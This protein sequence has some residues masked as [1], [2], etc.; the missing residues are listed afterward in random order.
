MPEKICLFAGT[1]EGHRLAEILSA[2]AEVTACVATEY[3]E[4]LLDG[5]S[6]IRVH[7]G[8]MDAGEMTRFFS[9]NGFSRIIDATHPYADIVT[10]NI[11]AAAQEAGIPVLRIL[12]ESEQI[13]QSAVFVP[14]AASA[15]EWLSGR[16]G[17]ILLTTGSKDLP[18]YQ[19]L[20][21]ERVWARVLPTAAS[22]EACQAAGIP[23]SHIIAAQG[24]FP[25]EIN[26]A[27][28][29]MIGARYLVTK[30]S[31]RA[32]GFEEKL[33]AAEE[34]GAV[35]VI[36]G[37]PAQAQ[38]LSL[39]KAL[40]ELGKTLPI[41]KPRVTVAGI[42][43]G[44]GDLLTARVRKVLED[45]DALIGARSV[46]EACPVRKPSYDAFQPQEIRGILDAHPS[47]RRAAVVMRGDVGFCSGAKKLLG[48]LDGYEVSLEP[49]ISSLAAFAAALGTSWDDAA[50]ISLHG[51]SA[52]LIQ[53]V[54]TNRKTFI[55]TGGEHTPG[56]ICRTLCEFGLGSLPASV[57]ERISYPDGKITRG[58]AAELQDQEFDS[59]SIL[60][61]SNE[62]ASRPYRSGI[63]DEEFIRGDA[64]MTK[65]EVRA[66]S[67]ARLAP[68][69]DAL[70]YD[71]GAGTGSVSVE[72]ALAARDGSVY[73]VEKDADAVGLLRQNRLRF[74]ADNL[75]IVHG[76]APEALES[77]PAPTH[78]F[79]GGSSGNLR[80]IVAALLSKNPDVRIVINAVTLETQAEAA[81][82][83]R[84]FGFAVHETVTIQAAYA[85]KLGR[86]HLM[87]GQNPVLIIT[88]QGGTA[89]NG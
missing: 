39:D 68:S 7:T 73:A 78:A 58:T 40:H 56:A 23:V 70:V 13:P 89:Q 88:L 72:C 30:V 86:Y 61:L 85:R 82:C 33:L 27:Q 4:I 9:E 38:G 20:N 64:P 83:A 19:G 24:P 45:C 54:R 2:V 60:Y 65:S 53:T 77:L 37:Q 41:G 51:R 49:G 32:G 12:R 29:R 87:T 18:A 11:R 79:I 46:I 44:S 62:N 74:G 76:A 31:G 43:P 16:E 55:L 75:Q 69:S 22:L 84:V 57:G 48:A 6:G 28:L 34:A 5:I 66:V 81:E 8:R 47:I 59:L 25:R 17:N 71:I 52:N 35:P 3:G 80:D 15:R 42:G 10:E 36:I 1:M 63:P 14:D 21:M 67:M 50:L 26:T